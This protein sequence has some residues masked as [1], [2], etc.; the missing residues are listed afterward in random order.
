MNQN[1]LEIQ[2]PQLK[3]TRNL[4]PGAPLSFAPFFT[5]F[6]LASAWYNQKSRSIQKTNIYHSLIVFLTFYNFTRLHNVYRYTNRNNVHCTSCFHIIRHREDWSTSTSF[7]SLSDHPEG[8]FIY[9]CFSDLQ[10][11]SQSQSECTYK[12]GSL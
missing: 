7:N 12:R 6:P 1:E 9:H 10:I 8:P 11:L 5:E 4:P 3:E 2:T